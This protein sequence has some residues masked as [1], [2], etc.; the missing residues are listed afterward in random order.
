MT[1]YYNTTRGP[2]ALPLRSGATVSIPPKQWVD[3]DPS[4]ESS[5]QVI[6][7][8]SKG[9]LVREKVILTPFTPPPA[10]EPDKWVAETTA[11][12]P[13]TEPGPDVYKDDDPLAEKDN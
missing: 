8:K 5:A 13:A 7:Y 4:D 12:A 10:P 1:R 3:I 11:S 2:L 6:Q 9:F